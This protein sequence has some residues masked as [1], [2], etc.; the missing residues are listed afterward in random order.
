MFNELFDDLAF[1]SVPPA[2]QTTLSGRVVDGSGSP[3]EGARVSVRDVFAS[4]SG[5][6]GRFFISRVPAGFG[7]VVVTA[8]LSCLVAGDVESVPTPTVAGGT[9]DVGDIVL[10]AEPTTLTGRVVDELEQPVAGAAVKVFTDSMAFTA[11]TDANGDFLIADVA[12]EEAQ[13]FVTAEVGGVSLRGQTSVRLDPDSTDAGWIFIFPFEVVPDPLTTATGKVVDPTGLPVAG[14]KVR[15]FTD[16]DVFLTTTG[17]DGTFTVS[18]VPTVNGDL[19]VTAR[20][21]CRSGA[22][23]KRSTGA[24]RSHR[25]RGDLHRRG[26]GGTTRR[27]PVR[28]R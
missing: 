21:G 25:S 11:T 6:D 22:S 18:G 28:R 16:W 9:T 24:W 8:S 12:G 26:R 2:E 17:A 13:V 7:E 4:V 23:G 3:M 14:A 5:S 19:G 1:R 10:A 20:K 15:V 27:G